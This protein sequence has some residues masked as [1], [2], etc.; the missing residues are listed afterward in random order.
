M[1]V[2]LVVDSA[3]DIDLEEAKALGVHM[4]PMSIQFGDQTYADGVDLSRREFFEKLIESSELP[5][6]SQINMFQF[7]ECF[8]ELTADGSQVVVI[9]LSSKLSGTYAGAVSAARSFPGQ[10]FVVDSLNVC[11]GERILIQKAIRLLKEGIFAQELAERLEKDRERIK[12][13]A[14][15]G[16]LEY[17]Q[18]GGRISAITA[19]SGSVL[20]IKPVISIEEGEV[21]MIGKAMGSKKG[22]NLLMQL[23]SKSGGIDFDMPY[24]TAYSGLEDSLLQK[25]LKDSAFLF[26]DKLTEIPSYCIGSTIGTHVG[27]G[28]I[29][30]AFFAK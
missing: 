22:N 18:K 4:I 15:L 2:K 3:S 16:T 25:Y 21:K 6:T 13:M 26:E 7:E 19:V 24:A 12:L 29:A 27:P 11:I 9:T 17:L 10:V 20:H 8:S 23:I 28:A 1:A 5:T 14:L 30:V